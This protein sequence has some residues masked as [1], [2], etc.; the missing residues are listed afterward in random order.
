MLVPIS[1]IWVPTAYNVPC[2]FWHTR[3][4]NIL[5]YFHVTGPNLQA[6]SN[7]Q[8]CAQIRS[9]DG[10]LDFSYCFRK[11]YGYLCQQRDTGKCSPSYDII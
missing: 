3:Q 7:K 6:S 4:Y 11:S 5:F 10:F 2:G 8:D 9:E 1:G